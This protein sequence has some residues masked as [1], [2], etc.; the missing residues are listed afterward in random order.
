[1][2]TPVIPEYITVHLGAAS[3]RSA[4]NVT[5]S[6]PDYIKN[7]A[8]SEIYPTW[9]DA[10][11]YPNIYAIISFALN[12]VY[13]EYYPSQNYD[14]DITSTSA[15]DQTFINGREVFSNIDVIVDGIFNNYISRQGVVEPLFAAYCNGTTTTCAGLSQ[16]GS[17]NLA[18]QGY[19]AYRILQTYYGEDIDIVENAPIANITPSDP[20]R[21]LRVGAFGEDVRQV[22]LRLNRISKNYPAI[23]KIN[24]VS[25]V[26]TDE[27][28]A[29]VKKFQ[30]IFNL[31]V[32]GVVGKAT[33]YKIQF[34]YN[35]VKRLNEIAAEGIVLEEAEPFMPEVLGEGDEGD[36]VKILQYFLSV[37][38]LYFD[39]IPIIEVTGIYGPETTEAVIAFQKLFGL[40]VDGL[41]GKA[42]G[43]ALY[44]AYIGIISSLSNAEIEST[45]PFPGRFL[46]LGSTG[47]DVKQV[48][49]FLIV[50][51]SVYP[52]ITPPAVTGVFNTVTEDAVIEFQ[53]LF[54]ISP[55]GIVGTITWD[56]LAEQYLL[57]TEGNKASPEQYKGQLTSNS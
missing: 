34:L 24:P 1:M 11:L 30:E 45:L 41:A 18:N 55:T 32:D 28:E 4:Q 48:Q 37:V 16:W 22:Q 6:F 47:D 49:E 38:S 12:R 20:L 23:P 5:V 31:T 40:E 10:A 27:T 29:A 57:I 51:A 15:Q 19:D 52:S 13:T 35:A 26:Y 50:A 7:V 36:Y 14:F 44:D 17:V 43:S 39:E 25:G 33:W 46:T 21:P 53:R 3:D 2:S 9:P 56:E 8:S 42:T 54:D